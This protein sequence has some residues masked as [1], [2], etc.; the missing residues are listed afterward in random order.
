VPPVPEKPE[1]QGV[2]VYGLQPDELSLMKFG[3][4]EAV[5]L[6]EQVTDLA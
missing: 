2:A 6:L 3:D 5:C 1:R 4:R